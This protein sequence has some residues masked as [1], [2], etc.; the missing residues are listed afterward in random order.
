MF[1]YG[2]M[3]M[4]LKLIT[5]KKD[6]TN[7]DN[8]VFLIGMMMTT[9]KELLSVLEGGQAKQQAD[10]ETVESRAKVQRQPK[11]QTGAD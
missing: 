2:L 5:P 4:K 3:M 8:W 1:L 9:E 7:Q 11:V 6:T 10:Q